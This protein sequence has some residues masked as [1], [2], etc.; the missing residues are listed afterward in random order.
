M[1]ATFSIVADIIVRTC[2]VPRET[3]KPDSHLLHDLGIDSL[4]LL[5]L[6]FALEDAFATQV[7]F[8]QWLRALH[9]KQEAAEQYFVMRALCAS[10]DAAIEADAT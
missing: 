7:P 2:Q 5:D 8:E 6:G 10:I 1:P 9:M 4:E 3:I